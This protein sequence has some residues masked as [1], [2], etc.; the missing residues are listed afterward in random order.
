MDG[1]I[2][3]G[4]VVHQFLG[5]AP[6]VDA[7]STKTPLGSGRTGLDK[8][9]HGNLGAQ[10]RGLLGSGKSAGPAANDDEVVVVAVVALVSVIGHGG[11]AGRGGPA[12]GVGGSAELPAPGQ[13]V[14]VAADEILDGG[15]VGLTGRL[16]NPREGRRRVAVGPGIGHLLAK[17][18]LDE[19]LTV[20]GPGGE[21][22]VDHLDLGG[23]QDGEGGK[24]G[25]GPAVETAGR[26]SCNV[27]YELARHAKEIPLFC[28]VS[29]K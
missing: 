2:D 22:V 16:G 6:N 20:L 12:G 1:L 29:R 5:D 18:A 15:R 14:V 10:A 26:P 24:D 25:R 3:N 7:S 11:D 9:Q 27:Q 19:P 23:E 8:V 17:S 13:G 4:R 28:L 21:G